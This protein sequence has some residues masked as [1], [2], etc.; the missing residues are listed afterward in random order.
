MYQFAMPSLTQSFRCPTQ[1]HTFGFAW[2]PLFRRILIC[3]ACFCGCVAL[4]SPSLPAQETEARP[5]SAEVT[6]AEARRAIRDLESDSLE[7][8][9]AAEKLLTEMGRGVL[10][11][12]PQVSANTS[13]EMKIRLQRIRQTLQTEQLEAFVDAST[14]T[15]SGS[16]TV[17]AA[18]QEI[19]KQT[20]NKTE[21]QDD[22]SYAGRMV[23]LDAQDQPFWTVMNSIMSQAGLRINAFGTTEGPLI[24]SPGA[25]DT[26]VESFIQGPFL[27]Q[28]TSIAARKTFNSSLDGQLDVSFQLTWEPRLEPIFMQ[29]PM[30]SMKMIASDA[31]GK[32]S[33]HLASNPAAA[34]EVP[35]NLGS[36]STQIDL[37]ME[38]PSRDKSKIDALSGKF[39]IAMPSE[40]HQYEFSDLAS[41]A[42]MS[43]KFGDIE[44]T[45]EGSRRNGPVYEMRVK[46]EFGDDGGALESF[47]GWVLSNQAYL[48]DAN[49]K[50]LENVG[51]QRYMVT[52]NAVGIGY[53][54]QINGDP[55]DYRL[56]YE[57]PAAIRRQTIEFE[58][59]NI[60]LP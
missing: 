8:R 44:V 43:E 15:L 18:L 13:G 55:N 22:G 1:W 47:R 31:G 24:L 21:L 46:V 25:A 45:L 41:G 53:L 35:L 36:C 5:R 49:D 60:E 59:K 19:E 16:M 4:S 39:S 38:R 42:R 56:I 40:R 50:R 57:S 12:L 14:V 7:E 52:P 6:Y 23:Q 48:L 34:P 33:E 28:A 26:G 9:D 10:P 51:L 17:A 11:F 29:L 2:Y 58:M 32:S 54:F 3:T 30:N 27:M 20:K 37:Q